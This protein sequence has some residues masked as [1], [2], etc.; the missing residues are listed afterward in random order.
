MNEVMEQRYPASNWNIY[1]AQASDGDNWND[2]SPLCSKLLNDK[3]LP[4]VQYYSY[5]E[6]TPH[7]H[8]M[9]WHEYDKLASQFPE[10][11][12]MQQIVDAGDIYPVFR[13][14]FQ[15]KTT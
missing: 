2:D 12:A 8:Q 6:I 7:E 10:S 4:Y 5:I 1:A 9:L 15:R 13:N 3:I 11:F 14:L